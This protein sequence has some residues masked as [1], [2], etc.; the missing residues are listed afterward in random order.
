MLKREITGSGLMEVHWVRMLNGEPESQ[1][2]PTSKRA[3]SSCLKEYIGTIFVV[4][5]TGSSSFARN[6]KLRDATTLQCIFFFFLAKE[7]NTG[8]FTSDLMEVEKFKIESSP[9]QGLDPIVER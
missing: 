4:R 9:R 7:A 8:T 5:N 2:K 1:I 3:V 6:E